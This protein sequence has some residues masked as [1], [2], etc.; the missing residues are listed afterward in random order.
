MDDDRN[1]QSHHRHRRGPDR[2]AMLLLAG[3]VALAALFALAMRTV[4]DRP[5]RENSEGGTTAVFAPEV[6]TMFAGVLV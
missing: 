1:P 5:G 3:A 6:I 2:G 4:T